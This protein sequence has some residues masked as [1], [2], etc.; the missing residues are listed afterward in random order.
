LANQYNGI[1]S[2]NSYYDFVGSEQVY[3][4]VYYYNGECALFEDFQEET[5][6]HACLSTLILLFI[7]MV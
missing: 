2:G 3:G 5:L 6:V 1:P 7:K 4:C